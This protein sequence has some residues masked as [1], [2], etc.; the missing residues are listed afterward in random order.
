VTLRYR[1][2]SFQAWEW[3]YPDYQS[4][5]TVSFFNQL[6]VLYQTQL[7]QLSVAKG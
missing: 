4:P 6:R 1:Q 2:K 5:T 7:R 3:T